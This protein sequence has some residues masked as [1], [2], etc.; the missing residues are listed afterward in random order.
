MKTE[1]KRIK[2]KK[3]VESKSWGEFTKNTTFH[4][5]KYIFEKSPHRF[6]RLVSVDV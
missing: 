6:R 2:A 1:T 4:G 3:E 5:V